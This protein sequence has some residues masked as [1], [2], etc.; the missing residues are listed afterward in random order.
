MSNVDINILGHSFKIKS[1]DKKYVLKL[2][3]DIN[4]RLEE[5][6]ELFHKYAEIEVITMVA[7]EILDEKKKVERE[8]K[9]L[10]EL[11]KKMELGSNKI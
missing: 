7:L 10:K 8:Y 6:E 4:K 2:Q 5:K 1:D 11:A 3:D 9:Q